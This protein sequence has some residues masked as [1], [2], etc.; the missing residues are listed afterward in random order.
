MKDRDN[1]LFAAL[2]EAVYNK[3]IWLD[4]SAVSS[5]AMLVPT[6]IK[7]VR[8]AE[9]EILNGEESLS[10]YV[11]TNW[12]ILVEEL[13]I[14]LR[15]VERISVSECAINIEFRGVQDL[16]EFADYL[17]AGNTASCLQE[18]VILKALMGILYFSITL[19]GTEADMSEAVHLS[20]MSRTSYMSKT[21]DDISKK[22]KE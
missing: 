6:A 19:N 12:N 11:E 4:S 15:L 13:G 22:E 1:I 7:R 17:S 3:I 20:F 10:S 21:I 8:E 14:Y 16:K 18:F 9:K 2:L 5:V